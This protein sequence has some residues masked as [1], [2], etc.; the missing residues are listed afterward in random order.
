MNATA[1]AHAALQLVNHWRSYVPARR[2]RMRYTGQGRPPGASGGRRTPSV[3][4]RRFCQISGQAGLGSPHPRNGEGTLLACPDC[5][6]TATTRRKGRTALG[7]R[8]FR[9]QACRRRFHERTG[10]P[11][12]DRQ[13]P[14]DSVRLAVR[15]RLRSTLGF[16]DVAERLLQRGFEVTHEPIPRL[17]GPLRP[18]AR[19]PRCERSGAARPAAPGTWTR[20]PGRWPGA[21]ALATAPS[22][23]RGCSSTPGAA[24][25][26]TSTPPGASCGAWSRWPSAS[27]RASPRTSLRPTDERSAGS[28]DGRS[29]TGRIHTA[30]T[31]RNRTT[32]RCSSAIIRC[33]VSGAPPVL[34]RSRSPRRGRLP[35]RAATAL[36]HTLACT[37]RRNGGGVDRATVR[38]RHCASSVPCVL[39]EPMVASLQGDRAPVWGVNPGLSFGVGARRAD[40]LGIRPATDRDFPELPGVDLIEGRA[41]LIGV[42]AHVW[43]CRGQ[44]YHDRQPPSGEVLL[45]AHVLIGGDE[46]VIALVLGPSNQVSIAQLRPPSLRHGVDRVVAEMPPKRRGRALIEQDPHD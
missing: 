3:A 9:C 20:P 40:C 34:A 37:D 35:G 41:N 31:S 2:Q 10:T 22:T 25:T 44:Q 14:T 36:R 28:W 13:D 32:A 4:S 42:Q 29:C 23:A 38:G 43:P 6:S 1:S 12:N 16:R 30:T 26:G 45:V 18:A 7:S 15:W 19:G 39:T 27:R 5:A 46:D 11:F 24:R 17:G 33:S 8:R 21:G